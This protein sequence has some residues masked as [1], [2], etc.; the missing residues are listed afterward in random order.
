MVFNLEPR[1]VWA[2]PYLNRIC[3]IGSYLCFLKFK[4]DRIPS[5]V[6]EPRLC[7][8]SVITGPVMPLLALL[9]RRGSFSAC[10]VLLGRSHSCLTDSTPFFCFFHLNLQSYC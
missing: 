5:L 3:S 4:R 7:D 9:D 1:P 6:D 10:L 2:R 8:L